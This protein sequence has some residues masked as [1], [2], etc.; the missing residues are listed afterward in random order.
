MATPRK[1]SGRA[2][3]GTTAGARAVRGERQPRSTG[4]Q[5]T[6]AL[7]RTASVVA[8][9]LARV[10]EPEGIS[11]AQYRVLRVIRSCEPDGVAAAVIAGRMVETPRTITG[12]LRR[13]ESARLIVR[14]RARR[15][16][17]ADDACHVTSS[18]A[19]VLDRLD[20]LVD[21]ADE[22]TLS[23]L[24]PAELAHFTAALDA[25]RAAYQPAP[26]IRP[27]RRR[28]DRSPRG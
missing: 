4:Q 22:R 9:A 27:P 10:I 21:A 26:A 7:L 14:E 23:L 12:L 28:R 20:P 1:E 16:V 17:A 8:R 18:G 19:A 11:V 2:P 25:I 6:I 3:R 13:L 24:P 5:A 15:S